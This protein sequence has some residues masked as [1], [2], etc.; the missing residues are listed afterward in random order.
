MT[1][2]S[3]PDQPAFAD[4]DSVATALGQLMDLTDPGDQVSVSNISLLLDIQLLTDTQLPNGIWKQAVV[5]FTASEKAP[6]STS[7]Q[8][9]TAFVPNPHA[10]DI[11]NSLPSITNPSPFL[12]S[13]S[14]GSVMEKRQALKSIGVK[15]QALEY[16]GKAGDSVNNL[17]NKLVRVGV[18]KVA[19][20]YISKLGPIRV[21][22]PNNTDDNPR[23][24][25][26]AKKESESTVSVHMLI[27]MYVCPA[28]L[29]SV[30][31][32]LYLLT[33]CN[34]NE[35]MLDVCAK[36]CTLSLLQPLD[37]M[38]IAGGQVLLPGWHE[39]P[40][41]RQGP[42]HAWNCEHHRGQHHARAHDCMWL[43]SSLY[44][45]F[46]MV[47]SHTIILIVSM[48]ICCCLLTVLHT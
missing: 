23:D 28:A 35:C 25:S 42:L 36:C 47:T 26:N 39:V 29:V 15:P 4:V 14:P 3:M 44:L 31:P 37:Y 27:Y 1:D 48:L 11:Q 17:I 12:L 6:A 24:A 34:A 33:Y 30:V 32:V 18:D 19:R 22:V 10:A 38:V 2:T 16:T 9:L 13:P 43:V 45:R 20:P 41:V 46:Q 21:P 7:Q 40:G 8:Q 5:R